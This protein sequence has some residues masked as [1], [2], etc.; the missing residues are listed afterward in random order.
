MYI[1]ADIYYKLYFK[2]I[3]FDRNMFFCFFF[4]NVFAPKS[5]KQEKVFY[6]SN[7]IHYSEN[8]DVF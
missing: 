8:T 1:K 5:V 7:N 6:S 2:C 3:L 4:A